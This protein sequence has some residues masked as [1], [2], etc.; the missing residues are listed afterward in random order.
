[1]LLLA[2]FSFFAVVTVAFACV[3]AFAREIFRAAFGLLGTLCGV[4]AL[5]ALNGAV[6]VA[7]LQVIIY[8]GGVFVLFLFGLLVTDRPGETV[9]RRDALG[10]TAAGA[11]STGLVALLLFA[12]SRP[13]FCD[14][15]W[16]LG[17][18]PITAR[19]IG[20]SLLGENL[21]AFEIVSV[22]LV[23]ALVGAATIL[24]KETES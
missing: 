9:F 2:L 17:A 15:A 12:A 19:D 14:V 4:A 13:D 6:A 5:I 10:A 1:M 11:L 7:A 21:L 18:V 3:T 22:L 16:A 8:V 23:A 24:G 20:T